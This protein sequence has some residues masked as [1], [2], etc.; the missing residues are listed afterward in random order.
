MGKSR[1]KIGRTIH[2]NDFIN[3]GNNEMQNIP[4]CFRFLFEKYGRTILLNEKKFYALLTDYL[5]THEKE[6]KVLKIACSAGVYKGFVG[7][8]ESEYGVEQRK[9]IKILTND[10][11]L[12]FEWAEMA[13]R[14]LMESLGVQSKTPISKKE[15][16]QQKQLKIQANVDFDITRT[17]KLRAYY[18]SCQ[19][20]IIPEGVL[21]IG[22]KCF[23]GMPICKVV[24]PETLEEIE[25]R[26]FKDCKNLTTINFPKSLRR[27]QNC[28]FE[29]CTK[30][31]EVNIPVEVEELGYACFYKCR[32][33]S[34]ITIN[35]E[36]TKIQFSTFV[37][38]PLPMPDFEK[39][40]NGFGCPSWMWVQY[41]EKKKAQSLWVN[42]KNQIEQVYLA[43]KKI[44]KML[45]LP[46]DFYN[47]ILQVEKE[48]I[49]LDNW[50]V[51]KIYP[52][53]QIN[54]FWV[55][56]KKEPAYGLNVVYTHNSWYC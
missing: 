26:A 27:V 32:K 46:D 7:L 41:H 31:Q 3:Q 43:I 1:L 14:W 22:K 34:N 15:K 44:N 39:I 49:S 40:Y 48:K 37:G 53:F 12:G 30:L 33:L 4:D 28:S 19:E 54:W 2:N 29:K 35:L 42:N 6:L 9:A 24:F 20:V 16:S 45:G 11:L 18:G 38:C 55:K 23:E 10:Y 13:I 56:E 5:P 52:E 51:M 47:E 36:R 17:G 8:E 21:K 25:E 50:E